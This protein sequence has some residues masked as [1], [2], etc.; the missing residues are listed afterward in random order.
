M[1]WQQ[2]STYS[3][4][5]L[6]ES[7]G[8]PTEPSA[9]VLRAR[10]GNSHPCRGLVWTVLLSLLLL[11]A[12]IRAQSSGNQGS[13]PAGGAQPAPPAGGA[14]PDRRAGGNAQQQLPRPGA[15]FRRLREL[16]PAQQRR[17]MANNPQFQ[18]LPPEVQELIHERLREWNAMTP[19]QKERI[20]ER[21]EILEGL[22]PAQRQEARVVFFQYRDLT[23]ARRQAVTVAFRHLR[24]LSPDQ[25]RAYLDSQEA[26]EQFSPHERD[27]LEGLNKLLPNSRP[28]APN[29]PDQERISP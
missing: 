2:I 22:S 17:I 8:L 26:R 4:N 13:N 10:R 15:I 28:A 18:R 19:Q 25:R 3:R 21:E 1:I 9:A 7:H 20:R 5:F 6:R 24:D 27:I 11:P 16:P 29:D 12:M 14:E 23:P